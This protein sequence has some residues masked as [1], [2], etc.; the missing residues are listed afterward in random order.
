MWINAVSSLRENRISLR[1]SL[2][3]KKQIFD[4]FEQFERDCILLLVFGFN[5][6]KYGIDLNKSFSLPSL[7]NE[8]DINQ[9]H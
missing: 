7:L 4:L 3:R 6:A 5:N 9:S 2:K 8:Q 1:S